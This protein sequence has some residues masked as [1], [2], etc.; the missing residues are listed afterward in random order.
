[1]FELLFQLVFSS[2]NDQFLINKIPVEVVYSWTNFSIFLNKINKKTLSVSN[3]YILLNAIFKNDSYWT[4]IVEITLRFVL[5]LVDNKFCWSSRFRDPLVKSCGRKKKKKK[6][7]RNTK[8][9]L[10][11]GQYIHSLALGVWRLAH[12]NWPDVSLSLNFH[13]RTFRA[14]RVLQKSAQRE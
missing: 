7:K 14:F 12:Y 8:P 9:Q 11:G 13:C 5:R 2:T 4:K 6:N 3:S 10:H 1:M